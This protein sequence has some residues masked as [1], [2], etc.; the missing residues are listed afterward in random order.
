[1]KSL[2]KEKNIMKK[3]DKNLISEDLFITGEEVYGIEIIYQFRKLI[4]NIS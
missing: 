3:L 4:N 2:N 1:M